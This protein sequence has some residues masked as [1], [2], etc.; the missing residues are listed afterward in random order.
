VTR[1]R[2]RVGLPTAPGYYPEEPEVVE[3][4]LALPAEIDAEWSPSV[5]VAAAAARADEPP[6]A[7]PQAVASPPVEVQAP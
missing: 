5:L 4:R 3:A 2:G 6:A 1:V 7:L